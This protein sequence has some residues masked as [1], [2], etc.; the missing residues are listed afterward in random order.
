MKSL[1]EHLLDACL[2]QLNNGVDLESILAE[3]P[4]EADLL[5]PSLV[6]ALAVKLDMPPPARRLEGKAR[7]MQSVAERRRTV[8]ATQGYI[9]EIKAGI[10][11]EEVLG[12][13][14]AGMRDLLLA[15]WRMHSTP[16]PLPDA[17]RIAAGKAQLIQMAERRQAERRRAARAEGRRAVLAGLRTGLAPRPGLLRRARAGAMAATMA[18]AM[19]TAGLMGVGRAAADSLPGD[20]FYQVKRLGESARMLFAWDPGRR[21]DLE[22]GLRARREAEIDRLL[23]AGRPLSAEML[24]A[25]FDGRP[26][27]LAQIDGLSPAA[28]ARLAET[29]TV[30]LAGGSDL[31]ALAGDPALA[32]GLADWLDALA[33]ETAAE[34]QE[35]VAPAAP[36]APLIAAPMPVDAPLAPEDRAAAAGKLAAP[37]E[38]QPPAPAPAQ[39]PVRGAQV[40]AVA[41]PPADFIQ[42]GVLPPS[43]DDEESGD[44]ESDAGGGVPAA[45]GGQASAPS[46]TPR[47]P[48]IIQVPLEP[49]GTPTPGQGGVSDPPG[50]GDNPQPSPGA[51]T[52]GGGA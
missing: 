8:E 47:P 36:S 43:G 23:R 39:A 24:Q 44:G 38:A 4:D 49:T 50:G 19:L 34:L 35:L 26:D 5:R 21:A 10:P 22:A 27:A 16:A 37:V 46:S 51:A 6:A 2:A 7:L 14:D 11:I 48:E 18:M 13:A 12:R 17:E 32:A 30:L 52:P 1:P 42:P 3:H 28:R 20:T 9:N 29:L 15:A 31:G 41:P 40:P 33:R 45:G 25:W